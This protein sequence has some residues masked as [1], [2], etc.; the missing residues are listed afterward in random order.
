MREYARISPRFWMGE[1]GREIRK[2]GVNAQLL[3]L[4]LLTSPHSNMIGL[5]WCPVTYMAHETGLSSDGALKALQRL[6]D[7]NFCAYDESSEV[8]WVFEMARY[9]IGDQLSPKDKQSKGVQNTY[10]DLP[11]NPFLEKFFLRYSSA[12][13]MTDKRTSEAPSKPLASKAQAQAQEQEKEQA[14]EKATENAS[15][16]VED[17]ADGFQQFWDAWPKHH[18]KGDRDK[19][20]TRWKSEKLHKRTDEVLASLEAWKLSQQW[21]KDGGQFIP[22]PLVFLRSE[23]YNNPLPPPASQGKVGAHSGFSGRNYDNPDF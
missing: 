4:Y 6:V 1:T 3:A 20:L 15:G 8:I 17:L 16:P 14:T 9:Q 19:C 11:K 5:Y 21:T 10:D 2:Q 7:I 13:C 22:A 12:F 18:R 23:T